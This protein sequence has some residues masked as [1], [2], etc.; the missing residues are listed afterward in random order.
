MTPDNIFCAL[1]AL[2]GE[3]NHALAMT[4]DLGA[5]AESNMATVDHRLVH[6][7]LRGVCRQ[8]P[9]PPT[10]HAFPSPAHGEG[11]PYLYPT[12][13]GPATGFRQPPHLTP[14]ARELPLS[15]AS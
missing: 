10:L 1:A 12:Q 3:D 2:F 5:G 6:G 7:R 9:Q 15:A 4:G 14:H 13:L 11:A 8:V